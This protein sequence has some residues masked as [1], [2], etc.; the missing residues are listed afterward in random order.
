MFLEDQVWP[1][2]CGHMAGKQVIPLDEYLKKLGAA[3]DARGDSDLF[4]TAR[5]DSRQVL[6]LEEAIRR[7]VAFKENGADA[8]FVEA[9]ETA[10]EMREIARNVPG[11]LVAN[12]VERG[13]TPLMSREELEELGF[14][15]VLWPV[16]PLFAA[17]NA[18]KNYYG[19]LQRNGAATDSIDR[20][21]S[22]DEFTEI[23]GLDAWSAFDAKYSS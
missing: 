9:P 14:A 15:L 18:L 7:G 19:D 6:G 2:R 1:K 22:F 5:T 13:V 23:V 16:G 4:I 12:M 17:A 20:V 3:I 8:V 21:M 11:P 10:A